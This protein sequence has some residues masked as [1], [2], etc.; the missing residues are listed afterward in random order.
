[1]KKVLVSVLSVILLVGCSNSTSSTPSST[2]SNSSS[3]SI[4]SSSTVNNVSSSPIVNSSTINSSYANDKKDEVVFYV[5]NDAHGTI[6]DSSS[7]SYMG[8]SKLKSYIVNDNNYSEDT[9][10]ILAAGDMW[11][12][13]GLS[14][15]TNG[16]CMT[17]IMNAIGF[18]AMAIG[19]HEFD[20]GVS[21]IEDN[22]KVADFPFLAYDIYDK[23]TNQP[24][25]WCD[26]YTIIERGGNKIGVIGE[27]GQLESFISY[28]IIKDYYF[29]PDATKVNSYAKQLRSE[30]CETVVLLTHNGP[31]SFYYSGLDANYIDAIFGGHTHSFENE[32][33]NGIPYIQAGSNTKGITK[34]VFSL[35]NHEFT[36][37]V[38]KMFSASD[39]TSTKTD[40]E[41]DGIIAEY[42]EKIQPILNTKVGTMEGSLIRYESEAYSYG[43]TKYGSMGKV[44]TKAMFDFALKDPAVDRSK[45]LAFHNTGGVRASILGTNNGT[46]DVIISDIYTVSPFDNYV[47]YYTVKG[48]VLNGLNFDYY[49]SYFEMANTSFESNTDYTIVSINYVYENPNN[50]LYAAETHR[51]NG[52]QAFIRDVVIEFFQNNDPLIASDY[53]F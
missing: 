20:W 46:M 36:S 16:E 7:S 42:Q 4:V 34:A 35:K 25:S 26:P 19:N 3:N 40:S 49:Y 18:D 45:L 50:D 37:S 5:I 31:S 30:G 1:M 28:S 27:I 33:Y 10:V 21:A 44:V 53:S 52:D 9:A 15:M 48:S 24:V 32:S 12:G 41:I 38:Y 39:V 11:Q 17:E 29:N 13:S 22:A 14:N 6:E 23:A 2:T 47:E 51:V 43:L 8:M